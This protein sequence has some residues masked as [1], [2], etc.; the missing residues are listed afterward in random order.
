MAHIQNRGNTMGK[1]YEYLFKL[2]IIGD[3]GVGKSSLLLRFAD[4]TFTSAYINTIGV[5]FKIRTV[6]YQ[7]KKIKLQIWDTAGQERFRTITATYYRGTHG[8]IVVYDVTDRDSYENVRRWMSEI[9]NNCDAVNRVLVG[10]K[11]D[12]VND[13]RVSPEEASEYA[14][15]LNIPHFLTSAKSSE[16]VDTMFEKITIMALDTKQRQDER[17]PKPKP[18]SLHQQSGKKKSNCC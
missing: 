11:V 2:L 8:V 9:D 5:D 10:N 14:T 6:E 18:V 13:I 3:A 15:K 12:M 4:D 1:D 17:T 16:Q 7:G